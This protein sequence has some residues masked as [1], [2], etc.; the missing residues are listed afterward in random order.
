[1]KQDRVALLVT[2]PTT[3]TT[4]TDISH[5]HPFFIVDTVKE[6]SSL[7]QINLCSIPHFKDCLLKINIGL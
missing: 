5:V 7:A 6:A 2:N 1:M 3:Y 4:D